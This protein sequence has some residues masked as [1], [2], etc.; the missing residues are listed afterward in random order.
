M[1]D[2]IVVV[3][4]ALDLEYQA[5]RRHLTDVRPATHAGTRFEIGS[6]R[7]TGHRVAIALV[8]KGN[9]AAAALTNR[10]VEVFDPVAVVLTGVA[11]ALYPG[12]E[13]GDL[14]VATHIYAYHG[15]TSLDTGMSAR[16][17]VWETAHS[18]IQI[19]QHLKMSGEW[20]RYLPAA[21]N[22]PRVHFAPVAAGEVVQDSTISTH[23]QWVREHYNDALAIEM[24]AAGVA[25]AGHLSG[26]PIVV[27]RGISDR[28]DGTKEVTDRALWQERAVTSA[29]A[30]AAALA[31]A[32][33]RE[34]VT[35][36]PRR[37]ETRGEPMSQ[38][39][40]NTAKD[41]ATVGM[42]VGHISGNVYAGPPSESTAPLDLAR[43]ISD[44]RFELRQAHGR[45]ELDQDYCVAAE[46]ELDVVDET[47]P[48]DSSERRTK[49]VLALLRL[50]GLV[51]GIA[52]L[53]GKV[54]A[55]I[56]A[57]KGVP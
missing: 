43:Q 2:D 6:L 44:L 49:A 52:Y 40:S 13:L 55:I 18:A 17:R 33:I 34:S 29:A 20:T 37:G 39:F 31:A 50:K 38:Q 9:H 21:T 42:M 53:V 26:A 1:A 54:T 24:E 51:D 4:T 10:A 11:G 22:A 35:A 47:I 23:A 5:V 19:A 45:G 3:L 12:I 32:L 25:Q 30:F 14:V 7:R 57:I 15:G 48:V 36:H 28:A 27:V 8:G 16:P 41:H 46:R 56:A